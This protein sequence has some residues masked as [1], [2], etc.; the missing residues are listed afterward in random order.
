MGGEIHSVQFYDIIAK[1]KADS[2]HDGVI[3][4]KESKLY[5]A[6]MQYFNRDNNPEITEE[7]VSK[8]KAEVTYTDEEKD[9]IKQINTIMSRDNL[10]QEDEKELSRLDDKIDIFKKH[11]V[12]KFSLNVDDA[13]TYLKELEKNGHLEEL[14]ISADDIK[15][16]EEAYQREYNIDF[17]G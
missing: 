2:N 13:I 1:S 5:S 8:Y 16:Y 9:I 7:D 14:G 11:Y 3:D 10:S 17:N 6:W 4:A 15:A 12:N